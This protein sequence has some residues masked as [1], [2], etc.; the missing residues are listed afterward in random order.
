[1]AAEPQRVFRL[2]ED[3]E[4]LLQLLG[5]EGAGIGDDLSDFLF[6]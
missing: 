2:G 6:G 1:M 5:R 3:L 4:E